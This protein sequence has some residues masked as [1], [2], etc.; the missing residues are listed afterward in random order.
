MMGIFI[1]PVWPI[2]SVHFCFVGEAWRIVKQLM[3][4]GRFGLIGDNQ[5]HGR[6]CEFM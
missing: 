1:L 6:R 3:I 4:N 5:L 2:K